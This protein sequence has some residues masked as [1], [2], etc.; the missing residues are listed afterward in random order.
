LRCKLNPS[1][2]LGFD[3]GSVRLVFGEHSERDAAAFIMIS[4]SE[5]WVR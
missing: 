4:H 2:D 3:W 1:R 5:A